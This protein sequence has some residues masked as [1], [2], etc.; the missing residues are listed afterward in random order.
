VNFYFV[1]DEQPATLQKFLTKKD[2]TLPV[3]TEQST[4][5]ALLQSSVLPSTF[6]I[7]KKGKIAMHSTGAEKWNSNNVHQLLDKLLTE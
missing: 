1:S 3:F 7:S 6:V 5:P 2:Y 4:A